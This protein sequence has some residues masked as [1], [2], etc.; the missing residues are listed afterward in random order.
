MMSGSVVG[1]AAVRPGPHAVITQ[2]T[3]LSKILDHDSRGW[4][5]ILFL[6]A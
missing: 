5:K 2:E 6:P 3:Y 1:C 4:L